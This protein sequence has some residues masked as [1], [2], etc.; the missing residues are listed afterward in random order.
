M[1]AKLLDSII[2]RDMLNQVI[3]SIKK[4]IKQAQQDS[5]DAYTQSDGDHFNSVANA[6]ISQ[7]IK[8]EKWRKSLQI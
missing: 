4:D 1:D 2:R 8:L 7:K 5:K 3:K 6:L